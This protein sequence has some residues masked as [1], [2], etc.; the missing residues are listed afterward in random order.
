METV[1]QCDWFYLRYFVFIHLA[2]SFLLLDKA[3][4]WCIHLLNRVVRNFLVIK[5]SGLAD[6]F[7]FDLIGLAPVVSLVEDRHH[8][9]RYREYGIM[10]DHV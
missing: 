5:Q 6:N 3:Q 2:I 1:I 8:M 10:C 7:S 4:S 9:Q